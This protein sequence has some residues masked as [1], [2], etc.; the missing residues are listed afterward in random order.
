MAYTDFVSMAN[1]QQTAKMVR[2]VI[3]MRSAIN[4]NAFPGNVNEMLIAAVL[5]LINVGEK[6]AFGT[7]TTIQIV[8][9]VIFKT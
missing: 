6:P 4:I 1:V 3:V 7:V 9:R 2:I 5:L 8:Q